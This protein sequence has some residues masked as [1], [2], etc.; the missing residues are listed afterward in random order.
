MAD[1]SGELGRCAEYVCVCVCVCVCV[2]ACVPGQRGAVW[3]FGRVW[4]VRKCGGLLVMFHRMMAR[5]VLR[6]TVNDFL[7]SS[8]LMHSMNLLY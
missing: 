7:P 1:R 6:L 4:M 8:T 2:R 3:V 5:D